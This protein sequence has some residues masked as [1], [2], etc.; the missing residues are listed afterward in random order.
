[1]TPLVC[2]D[3]LI[4]LQQERSS[5]ETELVPAQ[6]ALQSLLAERERRAK[7]ARKLESLSAAK[8]EAERYKGAVRHFTAE[9]QQLRDVRARLRV[10]ENTKQFLTSK[11]YE[12][13]AEAHS[14]AVLQQRDAELQANL[15]HAKDLIAELNA[16][17]SRFRNDT[18]EAGGANY[19][20]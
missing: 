4:Q 9:V 20:E 14:C 15:A 18:R 19:G 13:R 10:S 12:A 2:A 7:A 1:M 6:R 5:C 3:D 16:P 17:D 11:L 8:E